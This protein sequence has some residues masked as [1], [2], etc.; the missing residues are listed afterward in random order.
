MAIWHWI[1]QKSIRQLVP[2]PVMLTS[3]DNFYTYPGAVTI[4]GLIFG[5]P[6]T[7]NSYVEALTPMWMVF[8]GGGLWDIIRFRWGLAGLAPMMVLVVLV[9]RRENSFLSLLSLSLSLSL[10]LS[11]SQSLT[12]SLSCSFCHVRTQWEEAICKPR[13]GPSSRNRMYWYQD[14]QPSSFFNYE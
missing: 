2:Q 3:T 9:R 5:P 13:R 8:G 1:P 7:P 10:C 14:L 4:I 12:L 11:H 6:P